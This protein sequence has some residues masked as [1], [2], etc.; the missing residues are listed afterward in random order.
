[1]PEGAGHMHT[2]PSPE[3]QGSE[4]GASVEENKSPHQ[5]L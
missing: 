3:H 5:I 2:A 4:P 1:M